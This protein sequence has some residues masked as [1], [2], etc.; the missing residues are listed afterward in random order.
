MATE[1]PKTMIADDIE[2]T[3]SIKCSNNIQFDG[4][5]NGDMSCNGTAVIGQGAS[6]RGNITVDSVTVL[7]Q[8]NGNI[9]AKDRIE[10]K[11]AAR[12]NGDIKARRLTV[13]D[14][15]TFIGKSEVNPATSAAAA[16]LAQE[17][18]P[19]VEAEKTP[20]PQQPA[21][22]KEE[23]KAAGFFGKR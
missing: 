4:K 14:G 21:P 22:H 8:V 13:E 5:L 2:I 16:A 15:V 12:V 6:I 1:T 10:L 3:G 17:R 19:V 23:Q 11:S 9:A 20:A 7:G 18:K